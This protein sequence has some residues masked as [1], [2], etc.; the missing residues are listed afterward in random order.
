MQNVG[1]SNVQVAEAS[2]APDAS[3]HALFLEPGARIWVTPEAGSSVWVWCINGDS[4]VVTS[5]AE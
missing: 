3:D 4:V 2:A 5:E 1:N